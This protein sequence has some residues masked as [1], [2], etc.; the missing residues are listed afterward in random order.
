MAI[1]GLGRYLI[2]YMT[3]TFI[4]TLIFNAIVSVIGLWF[5]ANPIGGL[6]VLIEFALIAFPLLFFFL[7]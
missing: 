2:K 4:F 3:K 7:V 1:F 5:T 6:L